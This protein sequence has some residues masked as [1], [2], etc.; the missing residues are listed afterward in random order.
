MRQLY[1]REPWRS[2]NEGIP[3]VPGR[4]SRICA[5]CSIY[6][7]ILLQNAEFPNSTKNLILIGTARSYLAAILPNMDP[8]TGGECG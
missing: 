7:G 2:A 8:G 6:A 5:T 4:A 1:I 3:A